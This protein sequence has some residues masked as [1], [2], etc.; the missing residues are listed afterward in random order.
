[1][2]TYST[3]NRKLLAV[4]KLVPLDIVAAEKLTRAGADVNATSDDGVYL[5]REAL[6][7][8]LGP[9]SCQ[10]VCA[11]VDFCISHGL[12]SSA[13]K[14]KHIYESLMLF[15]LGAYDG[16]GEGTTLEAFRKLLIFAT[17]NDVQRL[18]SLFYEEYYS[19]LEQG[20]WE[21]STFNALL[22]Q[23]V[24]RF[25][26]GVDM[27]S[28]RG[29][30]DSVGMTVTDICLRL[31]DEEAKSSLFY[32]AR[33]TDPDLFLQECHEGCLSVVV[34]CDELLVGDSH[35]PYLVRLGEEYDGRTQSISIADRY[36]GL[37]GRT[38]TSAFFFGFGCEYISHAIAINLDNGQAI[39]HHVFVDEVKQCICKVMDVENQHIFTLR[40][41]DRELV[42]LLEGEPPRFAEARRYLEYRHADVNAY[43]SR[44][45]WSAL[46]AALGH[47]CLPQREAVLDFFIEHGF[48]A[49]KYEGKHLLSALRWCISF[50]DL[51][52]TK[53][54]MR[55]LTL[56]EVLPKPLVCQL[57]GES[58]PL[59]EY[60]TE[61]AEF[62]EAFDQFDP[63]TEVRRVF[64]EIIRRFDAGLPY[65]SVR[66]WDAAEGLK[67]DDVR[68][69]VEEEDAD[70]PLFIYV[71]D[72]DGK[73]RSCHKGDL[74][75]LSGE[76]VLSIQ[77]GHLP[78][79]CAVG[80]ELINDRVPVSCSNLF[81]EL[82]GRTIRSVTILEPCWESEDIDRILIALDNGL[83]LKLGWFLETMGH[84]R[85]RL[86]TMVLTDG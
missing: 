22:F 36:P 56:A 40:D 31:T 38:I 30:T 35:V 82:I 3:L 14:G 34:G 77:D 42:G 46:G 23:T 26:N 1:M 59:I 49:T 70:Q 24:C 84:A 54:F 17:K 32:S 15:T 21:R 80:D 62:W 8:H 47:W 67:I 68:L 9:Y 11:V 48:D 39:T 18:E 78:I 16:S 65:Q 33:F 20:R 55:L 12:N 69:I 58:K 27:A 50:E 2:A 61:E 71:A 41:C 51:Q 81:P 13:N 28:I 60:L 66:G 73:L 4:L 29:W 52:Q 74:S 43:D 86:F 83:S 44:G 64:A 10:Q 57:G 5:L 75:F 7:W 53:L 25:R 19:Q 6:G 37:I 72:H 85:R 45:S 79:V 76:R 63:G